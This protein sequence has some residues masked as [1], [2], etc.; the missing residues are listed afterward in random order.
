MHS[1]VISFSLHTTPLPIVILPKVCFIT[2]TCHHR[3]HNIVELLGKFSSGG[4]AGFIINAIVIQW[5]KDGLGS[6]SSSTH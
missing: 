6:M 5:H 2:V 3:E 1:Y 4:G